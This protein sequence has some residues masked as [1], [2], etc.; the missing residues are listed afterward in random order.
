MNR[1][2]EIVVSGD[3]IGVSARWPSCRL[4]PPALIRRR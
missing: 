2:V 1:R 3:A 4:P